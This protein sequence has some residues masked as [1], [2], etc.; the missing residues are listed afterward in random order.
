MLHWASRLMG[1]GRDG[2][3]RASHYDPGIVGAVVTQ[4]ANPYYS[5]RPRLV[6]WNN[7]KGKR[8][9]MDVGEP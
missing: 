4:F 7:E 2:M 6:P 3:G 1:L 9:C 8:A 5:P